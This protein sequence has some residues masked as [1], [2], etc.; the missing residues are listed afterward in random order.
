MNAPLSSLLYT[1]ADDNQGREVSLLKFLL[2]YIFQVP[3][4]FFLNDVS[5]TIIFCKNDQY[6]VLLKIRISPYC[7]FCVTNTYC[8]RSLNIAKLHSITKI[9]ITSRE[10]CN[11]KIEH[12]FCQLSGKFKT[13]MAKFSYEE[14][15]VIQIFMAME[16]GE[17]GVDGEIVFII[18][19]CSQKCSNMIPNLCDNYFSQKSSYHFA[20]NVKIL[21]SIKYFIIYP[22]KNSFLYILFISTRRHFLGRTYCKTLYLRVF[23]FCTAYEVYDLEIS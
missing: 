10:T 16:A 14:S 1:K 22:S 7:S 23:E 12:K 9:N 13:C 21:I 5:G 11:T 19:N 18:R 4:I 3:S 15:R 6:T 20:M 2:G 17:C 8:A